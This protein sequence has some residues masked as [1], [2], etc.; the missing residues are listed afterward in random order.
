MK[1]IIL[2]HFKCVLPVYFCKALLIAFEDSYKDFQNTRKCFKN[3]SSKSAA[4]NH[5]IISYCFR[6]RGKGAV[7]NFKR[8]LKDLFLKFYYFICIYSWKCFQYFLCFI[9][10]HYTNVFVFPLCIKTDLF[11]F[12]LLFYNISCII[13]L[14]YF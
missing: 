5:Y 1:C 11:D 2:E 12:L 3:H 10:G 4:G 8:F 7:D 9:G 13:I 14:I 6:N